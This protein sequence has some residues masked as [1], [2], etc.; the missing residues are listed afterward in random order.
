M[1]IESNAP[2]AVPQ[3]PARS[4]RSELEALT[5]QFRQAVEQ[6]NTGEIER[7]A[8]RLKKQPQLTVLK[9]LLGLLAQKN[10]IFANALL[11]LA[12]GGEGPIPP[13]H[14]E[15]EVVELLLFGLAAFRE[16]NFAASR[17]ALENLLFES[18]HDFASRLYLVPLSGYLFAKFLLAVERTGGFEA[19]KPRVYDWLTQF[20]GGSFEQLF[21]TAY[22][23]L[24]R[25]LLRADQLREAAQ[26][27]K[28]CRFPEH[29]GHSLLAKFLLY[30]ATYLSR[31]GHVAQAANFVT[32]ALRKAPDG[33]SRRGLGGFKLRARKLKLV[34]Q[35][36]MNEPPT[37][38][39]LN[40]ARIPPHYMSLVHAVNLG[41]HDEFER[42]MREHS[43]DFARDGMLGL[44][45]KMRSVV[46]KNALKKMSLAYSRISVADVLRRVGAENDPHFD[47]QAFLTKSRADLPDF[48]VDHK[49]ACLEF[50]RLGDT[51]GG[52]QTRESLVKRL[53]HLQGLE[54][55]VTKGLRY[56]LA[57]K[58]A[59]AERPEEHSGEDDYHFSDYSVND[60]DL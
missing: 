3:T 50:T 22:V 39:W 18:P 2:D 12:E 26:L 40:Y 8:H 46:M 41:N 6:K 10:S 25:N 53:R 59:G 49:N 4:L 47:L 44:L 58:D 14:K 13:S 29:I 27:L 35:L 54:E 52:L 33:R 34:L 5:E 55:Q 48:T 60:M 45:A 56:R 23:F 21:A 11:R 30:K 51:Y 1:Q 38:T 20:Q 31:I 36:I 9:D 7:L 28:N 19:A 42:L 15:E 43:A 37:H 57:A 24:L 17:T 16:R 32:E